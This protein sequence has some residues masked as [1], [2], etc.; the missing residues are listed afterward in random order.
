MSLTPAAVPEPASLVLAS[1]GMP[2]CAAY[3]WLRR[4]QTMAA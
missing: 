3:G 4:R 1:I 2:L